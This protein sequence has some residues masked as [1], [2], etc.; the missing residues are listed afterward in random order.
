M[1]GCCP[2]RNRPQPNKAKEQME[3]STQRKMASG[4]AW[5]VLFKLMERSLGLIS[6]LI[7]VRLLDPKDFGIVAMAMSFIVMAELLTNFGFDTALIQNQRAE[8]HLYHT[9]W[10]CNVLFGLGSSLF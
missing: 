5:M 4:A 1:Y 2:C 8:P 3:K 6:T 10:T 9:A 7:L